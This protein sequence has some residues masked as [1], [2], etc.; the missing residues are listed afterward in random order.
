MAARWGKT[1]VVK[2][3]V[4]GEADLNLQNNVCQSVEEILASYPDC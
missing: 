1:G 4:E 2:E 3:L